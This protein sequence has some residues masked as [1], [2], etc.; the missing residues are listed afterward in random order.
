MKQ[1]SKDRYNALLDRVGIII[2]TALDLEQQWSDELGK[3]HPLYEASA[4]NLIHY[5]AFRSLEIDR[6]QTELRDLGLPSLSNI[7]AHVMQ[8]LINLQEILEHLAGRPVTAKPT[9]IITVKKSDKLL[10]KNTKSI[11]GYRSKK[12]KTRIMVTLPTTAAVDKDFVQK[13]VKAGMNCARINCAHDDIDTWARMMNHVREAS[14]VQQRKVKIAMDLA[15]P[16]L[17]T[18]SMVPGPKITHIKPQRD[19]LGNITQPAEV[20]IAPYGVWPPPEHNQAPILRI[21]ESVFAKLKRGSEFIFTDTRDKKITIVIDRKDGKGVWGT[22]NKS[23]Y[24]ETGTPFV[25]KRYKQSGKEVSRVGELLPKQQFINLFTGDTLVLHKDPRHGENAKFDDQGQLIEPAHISC[26]LPQA[27]DAMQVGEPIFFDD[28]KIEGIVELKNEESIT[29]KIEQAKDRG[30]KLRAD[31]G[32]NLP[33]TNLNISGLT[34]KDHQD[35]KFV[36]TQA[37]VINYSFV[38][39]KNDVKQLQAELIKSNSN[40][41]IVLK[42]ETQEAFKKLPSILLTAMRSYPI[43]VMIARGDLAIEIG[44]KN[45]PTIQQEIMRM[46][47]AA[48]IPDVW[49]TQVLESLAK[50]G[51]PSRAEITDAAMAQQAACVMLNKGYYIHKAVKM[52]DKI[53]RRMER[54]QQK[55]ATVLPRLDEA[56]NLELS[57]KAFDV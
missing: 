10:R 3:V 16:K 28:G 6:L 21:D 54:F 41:G 1:A 49:A 50:K 32:I 2:T 55:N 48:H 46:C 15:G 4:K 7:E 8:S 23:A 19:D 18:G 30:S 17:R 24:V 35:L 45:F 25:H 20:W 14:R 26:T 12:R 9:G 40:C 34:E 44:W 43:G 53:L 29:I 33:D 56:R 37:D 27:I 42:I 39:S 52:L 36:A 38:N 51:T 22:C 31:K 47:G 11:F 57:H 5:L 13:L